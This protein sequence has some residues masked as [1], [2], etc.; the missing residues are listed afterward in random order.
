MNDD[1]E[2]PPRT[3][4]LRTETSD[5]IESQGTA[6]S[7]VDATDTRDDNGS[8]DRNPSSK[9]AREP[10]ADLPSLEQMS[11]SITPQQS[12]HSKVPE[13]ASDNSTAI[14]MVSEQDSRQIVLLVDDNNINLRLLITCAKRAKLPYTSAT[15][16][17][18]ALQA[19]QRA[20]TGSARGVRFVCMDLSMPVMDGITAV[21]HIRGFEKIQGIRPARIVALTGIGS[22]SVQ[23]ETARAG[24]DAFLTKPVSFKDLVRL[25]QE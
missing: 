4:R 7:S 16:G 6:P 22:D 15:N 14:D 8:A 17:L 23:R 25:L 3:P 1:P 24:F 19:Y 18:E 11:S 2:T 20:S 13:A 10:A 12:R 5:D 21:R 9:S